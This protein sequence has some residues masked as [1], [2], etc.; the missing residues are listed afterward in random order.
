VHFRALWQ[1]KFNA[2]FSLKVAENYI[3][4]YEMHRNCCQQSYSFWPRYA[5]NRLSAGASPQTPL[6]GAYSAPDPLAGLGG[7]TPGVRGEGGEGKG[8]EG[9][10]GIGTPPPWEGKGMEERMGWEGREGE[11]KEGEGRERK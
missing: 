1:A 7:R 11:G 6:G 10:G 9:V 4:S 5:P 3:Y 2:A 8:G